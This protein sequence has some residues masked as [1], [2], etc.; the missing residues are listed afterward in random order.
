M[1]GTYLSEIGR[2]PLLDKDQEQQLAMRIEKGREAGA[3]LAAG[4]DH[5][6]L[7]HLV[8]DGKEATEQFIRCNLR[9]VVSVA[10]RFG[11]SSPSLLDLIQ[12]GNLG[13]M[14]AVEKFDWRRGFKFSTYAVWWITQH[15]SRY[16]DR[17]GRAVKLPEVAAA[18]LRSIERVRRDEHHCSISALAEATG[19][20]EERVGDL[21]AHSAPVISLAYPLAHGSDTE[22]AETIVDLTD[23]QEQALQSML[24]SMLLDLMAELSEPQRRVM[25]LRY[26]IDGG[27]F[28]P[29]SEVASLLQISEEAARVAEKRALAKLRSNIDIVA[30]AGELLSA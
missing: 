5:E 11:G 13:L 25:T 14:H 1:L 22:V 20:K 8:Q 24:P 19:L 18:Q 7:L 4:E 30:E 17:H 16:L 29:R 2:Y 3:Q 15:I 23:T 21:L 9:L 10:K 26:G 6:D 12:E 28:R 27:G